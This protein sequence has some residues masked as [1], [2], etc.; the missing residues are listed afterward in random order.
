MIQ[1]DLIQMNDYTADNCAINPTAFLLYYKK[2][3]QL[4]SVIS[5]IKPYLKRLTYLGENHLPILYRI[6]LN[7][8]PTHSSI[9]TSSS[10]PPLEECE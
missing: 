5:N 1:V 3:S 7:P 10:R 8:R 6:R 9:Q 2:S 4:V